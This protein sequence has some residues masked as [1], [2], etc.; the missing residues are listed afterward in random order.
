MNS[1]ETA[2]HEDQEEQHERSGNHHRTAGKTS[3]AISDTMSA[4]S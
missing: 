1:A 3:V 2:D 4:S